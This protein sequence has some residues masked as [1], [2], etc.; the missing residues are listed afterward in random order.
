MRVLGVE[1]SGDVCSI[2]VIDGGGVLAEASFRHNMELSRSLVPHVEDLLTR[3][4]LEVPDVQGVAVSVGPGSFTGLRIGV[5]AAKSFAYAR[6]IPIAGVGTL[7]ALAA[8]HPAPTPTLLCPL[9]SASAADVFAALYQWN[10]GRLEV[11]AV[12]TLL[13]AAEMARRLALYPGSVAVIG[14]PGP[15]RGL[16]REVLQERLILG[17]EDLPPRAAT[18]ASLGRV[19]LGA[20]AGDEVH[21]LAPRYLR[22]SAA[23][24]RRQEGACP[25][26]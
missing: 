15:H 16:L 9:I 24:A 6:G 4:S 22:P 2:A 26:S 21:T 1:T 17:E 23:E 3:A 8:D 7:E 19:R 12:E 11:R 25:T 5:S 18:V 20:G 13:P 10:D 14:S